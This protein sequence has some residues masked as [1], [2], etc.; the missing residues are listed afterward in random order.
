MQTD[1]EQDAALHNLR[2]ELVLMQSKLDNSVGQTQYAV[3]D[4]EC[5]QNR[6]LTEVEAESIVKINIACKE[7]EDKITAA[8]CRITE[9]K[10][11]IHKEIQDRKRAVH[12]IQEESASEHLR[13]EQDES[14][15]IQMLETFMRQV[16]DMNMHPHG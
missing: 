4:L 14:A 8:V 1:V 13:R 7:L 5:R 2:G 15:I 16:K 11:D 12:N 10:C 9:I 3:D 6:K